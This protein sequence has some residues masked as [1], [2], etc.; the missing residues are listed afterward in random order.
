MRFRSKVCDICVLKPQ[1][2]G[3]FYARFKAQPRG[4]GI[5]GLSVSKKIGCAVV[6]N[7]IKRRLR[8][9]CGDFLKSPTN[10]L[11]FIVIAKDCI[12]QT[13]FLQL[14]NSVVGA[15]ARFFKMQNGGNQASQS[16]C[17]GA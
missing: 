2:L 4:V 11:V 17:G 8:A 10:A 3:A 9:I 7:L 16:N 14:K 5:V 15:L 6:R 1:D 12:A 13:P